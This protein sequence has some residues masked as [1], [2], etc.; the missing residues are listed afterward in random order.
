MGQTPANDALKSSLVLSGLAQ[1]IE[2]S[3]RGATREPGE[4][5][6][7]GNPGGASLWWSWTA[8]AEGW[9]EIATVGSGFDTLL[10][11]YL[12]SRVD[13]LDLVTANDDA[14]GDGSVV[15]FPAYPGVTYRIVVDGFNAGTGPATGTLRL[16]LVLAAGPVKRPPG[17]DWSAAIPLGP[18]PVDIQASSV[19]AT[20]E[21]GEPRHADKVGSNS[22]WYR[23]TADRSG[24]VVVST[25]GSDFDTLLAVYTGAAL[26]QLTPV[27]GNDDTPGDN[28]YTS[29]L[30]FPAVAGSTYWIAVDGYDGASGMASLSLRT[31]SPVA[32]ELALEVPEIQPNGSVRLWMRGPA[33]RRVRV[34]F[35]D[36][37]RGWSP[38]DVI[39]LGVERTA[40]T[41]IPPAGSAG[42]F[43]RGILLP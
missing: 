25:A 21:P 36:D 6:H 27:A 4:P 18:L 11:V 42:R 2:A 38:G 43:Y 23:W 35:S 40:W 7:A 20:R 37:L 26:R 1:E 9:T 12:G 8:P 39:T 14:T 16:S 22:L 24:V 17:D 33:A 34:E 30:E 28:G 41:E 32:S 31:G 13:A 19:N 15:R 10:G 3:N 29:Q 5:D